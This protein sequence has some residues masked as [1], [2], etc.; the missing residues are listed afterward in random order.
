MQINS[1][2]LTKKDIESD[3]NLLTEDEVL[4]DHDC[5]TPYGEGCRFCG[6]LEDIRTNQTYYEALKDIITKRSWNTK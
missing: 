5:R 2:E 1:D 4:G 3:I 6:R